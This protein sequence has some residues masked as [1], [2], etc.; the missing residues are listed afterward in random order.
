MLNNFY[1]TINT[2]C[3]YY[4]TP[5]P[6]ILM[7]AKI[8]GEIFIDNLSI[9]KSNLDLYF[10]E[11]P[12]LQNIDEQILDTL[13]NYN[14]YNPKYYNFDTFKG[15]ILNMTVEYDIIFV[16][17]VHYKEYNDF[18]LKNIPKLAKH[19]ILYHD[20]IPTNTKLTIPIRYS[21]ISWCGETFNSFYN[22][23]LH[24]KKNTFIIKDSYVGYGIIKISDNMCIDY[25]DPTIP[26]QDYLKLQIFVEHEE[27]TEKIL[28]NLLVSK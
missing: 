2:I 15:I 23:Y 26:L 7:I 18:I 14:Q 22:F 19:F 4:K 8:I 20:T 27:F 24:N 17:T 13:N 6:K 10:I 25:P 12:H 9:D 3:K 5:R 21:Q 1:D 11:E 16:D 28:N